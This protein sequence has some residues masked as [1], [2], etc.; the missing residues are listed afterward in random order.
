MKCKFFAVLSIALAVTIMLLVPTEV[1]AADFNEKDFEVEIYPNTEI[2][3]TLPAYLREALNSDAVITPY[4]THKPSSNSIH[5]LNYSRYDFSVTSKLDSTIYSKV[6]L[7]GHDGRI[8]FHIHDSSE[9]AGGYI[10]RVYKKGVIDTRVYKTELAHGEIY[11]FSVD[12]KDK[13]AKIYFS[14]EAKG[15]TNITGSYVMKG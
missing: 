15:T 13:D 7:T 5:D 9:A 4:G 12:I 6:V 8:T 1:K 11:D 2:E 3:A 14:V 10:L